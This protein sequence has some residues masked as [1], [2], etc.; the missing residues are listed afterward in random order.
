MIK[1]GSLCRSGWL[2]SPP[3]WASWVSSVQVCSTGP[4][5]LHVFVPHPIVTG[6]ASTWNSPDDRV[7]FCWAQDWNHWTSKFYC[8][9][10]SVLGSSPHLEITDHQWRVP[11]WAFP[12]GTPVSVT[13]RD[14]L[15]Y[16]SSAVCLTQTGL[17][18]SRH[19]RSPCPLNFHV[20]QDWL[21]ILGRNPAVQ[22]VFR[23]CVGCLPVLLR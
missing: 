13:V 11:F 17:L 2:F 14:C 12:W 21:H 15:H 20:F 22:S 10:D 7:Y 6:K 9:E 1:G 4:R 5:A 23:A 8:W 18:L 16:C 19:Q 3:A